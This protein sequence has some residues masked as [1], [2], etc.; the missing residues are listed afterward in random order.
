[1]GYVG[2]IYP[3]GVFVKLSPGKIR[4]VR[5]CFGEKDIHETEKMGLFGR[6][7]AAKRAAL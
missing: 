7:M 6:K 4:F 5:M 2:T 3:P 1:V